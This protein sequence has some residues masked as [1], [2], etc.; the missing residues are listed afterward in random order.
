ML[1]VLATAGF[2]MVPSRIA[3]KF[4]AVA[5]GVNVTKGVAVVVLSVG[6]LPAVDA[7]V[8]V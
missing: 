8:L 3:T 1:K 6:M 4:V 5:L 7:E 2:S